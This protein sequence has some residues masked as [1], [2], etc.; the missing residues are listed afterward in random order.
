MK[1]GGLGQYIRRIPWKLPTIILSEIQN[2]RLIYSISLNKKIKAI[3][4]N[5]SP[6]DDLLTMC[7]YTVNS[8]EN[9]T[10]FKITL[11]IFRE[12]STSALAGCHASPLSGW[13]VN[14][15]RCW[16]L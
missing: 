13:T 1:W 8:A 2:K 14:Y 11:T 12:E 9:F 5:E 15:W 7:Y 4:N 3:W 16:F 6:H 10:D